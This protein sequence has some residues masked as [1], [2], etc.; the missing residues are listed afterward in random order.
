MKTLKIWA[1]ITC[2]ADT[3]EEARLNLVDHVLDHEYVDD[4]EII[5]TQEQ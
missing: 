3:Y 1:I 4:F 5:N 2:T